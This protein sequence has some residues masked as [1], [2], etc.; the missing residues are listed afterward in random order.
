MV[1]VVVWAVVEQKV[2]VEIL[3]L[4]V[5]LVLLD[6]LL[7]LAAVQSRGNFAQVQVEEVVVVAVVVVEHLWVMVYVVGQEENLPQDRFGQQCRN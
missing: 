1:P 5:L 2:R 6:S 4:L 7:D 3:V